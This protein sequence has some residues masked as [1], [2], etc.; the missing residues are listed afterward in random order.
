MTR[1]EFSE[2]LLTYWLDTL[3][4]DKL[5][6][7]RFLLEYEHD[8]TLEERNALVRKVASTLFPAVG[9]EA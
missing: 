6:L 7:F 3:P 5:D 9:G 8:T 1:L 4:Q 2:K